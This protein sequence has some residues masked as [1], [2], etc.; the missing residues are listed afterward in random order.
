MRRTYPS[1]Y[2]KAN[3][4]K[5]DSAQ[6]VSY[7]MLKMEVNKEKIRYILQ[8][9]F[10]KGKNASQATEIVHGV[11]GTDTITANYVQFWFRRFRSGIFDVKDA[12]RTG[13]PVNRP[14]LANRSVVFHQDN[15]R[16]HMSVVTRQ[17]PWELVREVLMHLPYSPDLAPS[18][19]HL[20]L[21][22]QNSLS[23]KKLDSREDCA[24]R[25]MEFFANK[26]LVWCGS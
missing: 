19:Y 13:R 12:P 25:L 18:D 10:D 6:V 8:F 20:F 7:R 15:A 24:N 17:K 22:L 4:R 14:E 3:I 26:D 9:F 5:K 2:G 11:Y 23:D 16:P 1:I 21:A